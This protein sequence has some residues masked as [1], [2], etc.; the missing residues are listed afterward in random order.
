MQGPSGTQALN[1]ACFPGSLLAPGTP[2]SIFT[3]NIAFLLGGH[4]GTRDCRL[5]L[6]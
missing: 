1:S 5:C 3:Y 2:D 6:Y 4:H